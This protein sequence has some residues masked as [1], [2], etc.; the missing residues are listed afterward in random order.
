MSLQG[1]S[2]HYSIETI[3]AEIEFSAELQDSLDQGSILTLSEVTTQYNNMMRDHD[4]QN[5]QIT[6]ALLLVKIEE[7]INKQEEEK[8]QSIILM[9][10]FCQQY[11]SM[12]LWRNMVT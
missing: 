4:I 1:H 3:S 12:L 10:L 2:P 6:R 5:Q 11:I 9:K 8:L 7:Q